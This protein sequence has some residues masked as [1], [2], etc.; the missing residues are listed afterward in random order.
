[1]HFKKKSKKSS[2]MSDQFGRYE[3]DLIQTIK[4]AKTKLADQIPI[5]EKGWCSFFPFYYVNS[6][7]PYLSLCNSVCAFNFVHRS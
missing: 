4:S 7:N 5:A 1:M 3:Q 2:T 6:I